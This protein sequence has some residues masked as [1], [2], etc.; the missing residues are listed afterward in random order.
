MIYSELNLIDNYR[1]KNNSNQT[2]D[3][4]FLFNID[5]L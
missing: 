1:L 5:F 4:M 3:L 2:I